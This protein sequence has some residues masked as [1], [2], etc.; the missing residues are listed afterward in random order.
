MAQRESAPQEHVGR[1]NEASLSERFSKALVSIDRQA[2]TLT[3]LGLGC[4]IAWNTIAF[5]GSF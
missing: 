4:W 3:Y 5:S 2:P 1:Q